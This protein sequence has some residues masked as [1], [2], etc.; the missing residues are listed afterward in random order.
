MSE[1]TDPASEAAEALDHASAAEN[2][3]RQL[4]RA[5]LLRPSMTPA[6]VDVVLAHLAAAAAALP[7]VA[8]QL[9]DIREQSRHDHTLAMDSLTD[10]EDPE[11]AIDSARRHLDEIS[12]PATRLYR[13]LDTARQTTAHIA[14]TD[15]RPK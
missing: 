1:H 4:C 7:Q 9:S 5:T 8:S 14:V 11:L 3:I 12:E 10:T 13:L 2:A 15:H 6:E